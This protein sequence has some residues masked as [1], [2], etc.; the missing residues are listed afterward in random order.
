MV[1]DEK[2]QRF[3]KWF[4]A[5]VIV[6][7][8]CGVVVTAAQI[9]R[10]LLEGATPFGHTE[11]TEFFMCEGPDSITGCPREPISTFSSTA[12]AV[13]VCGHLEANGSVRLRFLLVYEGKPVG[14]FVRKEYR[15]GDVFEPIPSSQRQPGDYRVEVHMG[16]AK[17]ATTEFTIV[18]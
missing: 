3:R 12:E 7:V 13:Y 14:W 9:I 6:W 11:F 4:I 1:G 2:V 17:L 15:T 10:S 18:P 8:S 5:F 16:R